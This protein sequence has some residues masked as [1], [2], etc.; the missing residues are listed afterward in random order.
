MEAPVTH[1]ELEY[2]LRPI[3]DGLVQINDKLDKLND[4]RE[5]TVRDLAL[6]ESRIIHLE[7]ESKKKLWV[8][9]S[10]IVVVLG[11]LLPRLNFVAR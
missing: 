10:V 6:L 1:R 8:Y 11:W 4:Y 3:L 7:N 9:V 5:N 2:I